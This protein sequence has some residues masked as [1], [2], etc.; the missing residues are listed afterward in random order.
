MDIIDR[1]EYV[2]DWL[3]YYNGSN[4]WWK[5]SN[6]KFKTTE[7]KAWLLDRE[8]T[9]LQV[10]ADDEYR[11]KATDENYQ[12]FG[13]QR[14]PLHL[15]AYVINYIVGNS[16]EADRTHAEYLAEFTTF[17]NPSTDNFWDEKD[18]NY[19]LK[20]P[21]RTS[22]SFI[23][24]YSGSPPRGITNFWRENEERRPCS[25]TYRYKLPKWIYGVNKGN[26]E[27]M[28]G[29]RAQFSACGVGAQ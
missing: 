3:L 9:E 29:T 25:Y 27:Y 6:G 14:N 17:F 11:K 28:F 7:I 12:P 8:G 10:W 23:Q 13:G 19:W 22:I 24:R 5:D 15:M 20:P 1:T 4:A 16:I 18:W 2:L 26:D 21:H